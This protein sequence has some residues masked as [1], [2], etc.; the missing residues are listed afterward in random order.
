[1]GYVISNLAPQSP[2]VTIGVTNVHGII[3]LTAKDNIVRTKHDSSLFPTAARLPKAWCSGEFDCFTYRYE[4]AV[5]TLSTP[6]W[7][8]RNQGCPRTQALMHQPTASEG[9]RA[10]DPQGP[11]MDYYRTRSL[12]SQKANYLSRIPP[13][14]LEPHRSQ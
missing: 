10:C 5:A 7:V 6:S 8:A 9:M 11:C 13:F 12:K 3:L 1:M 14:W 4:G 2:G